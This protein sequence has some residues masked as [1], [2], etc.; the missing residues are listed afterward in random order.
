MVKLV[1]QRYTR[2]AGVRNLERNL[3]A[4]AR[5]AAVRVVERDQTVPLNKDVHQVSSPLLE[6]RLSDG[7]EVDMEVIPIGADHEIP[8]PLRIASPLVV[9]EAMLEKV[10]GVIINVPFLACVVKYMP[11]ETTT[12]ILVKSMMNELIVFVSSFF[13]LHQ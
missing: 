6:N 1:V 10:L 12:G 11:I 9:D 5:A 2:E 13:L 3:A 8:N 7:A 4:L